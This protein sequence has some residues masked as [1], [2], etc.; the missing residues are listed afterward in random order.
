MT[1]AVSLIGSPRPIW[2]SLVEMKSGCPPSW[3]IPTS[4]ET[5]VRVEDFSKIMARV[6]PL[7]SWCSIP[8]FCCSLSRRVRVNRSSSSCRVKSLSLRKCLCMLLLWP[9]AGVYFGEDPV[10]DHDHPVDFPFGHD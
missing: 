8:F 3:N 5:R 10:E 4:N 7:R 6:F 1:R 9:T 2:E